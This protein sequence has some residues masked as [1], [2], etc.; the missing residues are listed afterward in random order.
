MKV[1][2]EQPVSHYAVALMPQYE[3]EVEVMVVKD[4]WRDELLR[5]RRLH[6]PLVTE[7]A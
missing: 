5:M 1:C 7:W 4:G 2:L 3:S 6:A